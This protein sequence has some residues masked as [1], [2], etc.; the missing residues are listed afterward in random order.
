LFHAP[1]PALC[2]TFLIATIY[3]PTLAL[4]ASSSL[5]ASVPQHQLYHF[6]RLM[7]SPPPSASG[8]RKVAASYLGSAGI[9]F[10]VRGPGCMVGFEAFGLPKGVPRHFD[11][12][13]VL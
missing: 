8:L 2:W 13:A 5:P 12:A 11:G 3:S 6:N 10:D 4:E 7:H 1:R 9:Q